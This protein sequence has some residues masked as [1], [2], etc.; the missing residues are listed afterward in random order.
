[1]QGL[2]YAEMVEKELGYKIDRCVF[3]YP[4]IQN[5]SYIMFDKANRDALKVLIQQF[6]DDVKN[7]TIDAQGI[8]VDKYV[9]QYSGL[10]SLIKEIK[11]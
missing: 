4:F 2:I 10:I 7:G 11:R 6:I 1:M 5:E 8:K 9:D 3:R